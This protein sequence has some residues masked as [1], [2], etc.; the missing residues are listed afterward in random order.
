MQPRGEIT[1][2]G[3]TNQRDNYTFREI[4]DALL[5]EHKN[6][7][8]RLFCRSKQKSNTSTFSVLEEVGFCFNSEFLAA[9]CEIRFVVVRC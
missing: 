5:A 4:E 8:P 2:T 1:K 3:A 9:D 6:K 7:K